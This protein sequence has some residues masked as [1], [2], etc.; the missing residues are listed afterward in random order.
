MLLLLPLPSRERRLLSYLYS[1]PSPSP[2]PPPPPSPAALPAA[3]ASSVVNVF[4]P[5][6]TLKRAVLVTA[7]GSGVTVAVAVPV[8]RVKDSDSIDCVKSP[9]DMSIGDA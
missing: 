2:P 1:T 4:P 7:F 5:I 9:R 6:L 3:E 8:S